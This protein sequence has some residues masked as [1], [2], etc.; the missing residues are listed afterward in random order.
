MNRVSALLQT[1]MVNQGLYL[2]LEALGL[3]KAGPHAFR[4]GCNRRWEL[5]GIVPAVIRQ[6]MGHSSAT[7]TRLYT[8]EIPTEDVAAAFSPK[9]GNQIVVLENMENEAAA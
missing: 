4:R 3:N 8:G 5:A 7:M 1:T 9:I 6:Q 2:A